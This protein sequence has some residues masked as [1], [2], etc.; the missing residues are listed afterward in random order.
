[1][2]EGPSGSAVAPDPLEALAGGVHRS[3]LEVRAAGSQMTVGRMEYGQQQQS[4]LQLAEIKAAHP[5]AQCIAAV[6]A[7]IKRNTFASQ[8]P[9]Q[10]VTPD[11]RSWQRMQHGTFQ[12]L[13]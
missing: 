7:F 3:Y 11:W 1:M 10:Q 2:A 5:T 13:P 8:M 9:T 6:S 4:V 12:A